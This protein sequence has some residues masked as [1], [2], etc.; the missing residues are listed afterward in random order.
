MKHRGGDPG[1]RRGR[2]HRSPPSGVPGRRE[3]EVLVVDGGSRDATRGARPATPGR[4]SLAA[5]AG[6]RAA[7]RRRRARD[8]RATSLL[9]LHADTRLPPGCARRRARRA[10]RPAASRAVRSRFRFEPTRAGRSLGSASVSSSG[11][12]RRAWRCSGCPTATRRCSCG[13]QRSRRSAACPQAP[14]MEDLDL[15]RRAPPRRAARAAPAPRRDLAARATSR[16][17][18]CARWLRNARRRSAP[19]TLRRRPRA[20]RRLVR[21]VSAAA[22]ARATRG[23]RRS[24]AAR[25]SAG[26][27]PTCAAASSYYALG[28]ATTLGYTAGF[29]AV[30]ILVGLVGAGGAATAAGSRRDRAPRAL[31]RRRSRVLRAVLRYFSRTAGLQRRARDRV[32]AAQRPLRA[33]PAAA[34]VLLLPLAHRRPHEPLRQR[35]DRGAAAAR[36]GP[37]LP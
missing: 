24:R 7:A 25:C 20:P 37:A 28:I 22:A 27:A 21:A 3:V 9:F 6:S 33:P 12:S 18:C 14:I 30:P 26:S 29:V 31:A 8:R 15:V 13:A 17:A 2:A 10:R 23:D 34:P 19:G 5:C 16:A 32:R 11:A 36:A 1:A 35:P 4:A